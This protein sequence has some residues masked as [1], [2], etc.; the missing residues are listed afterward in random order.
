MMMSEESFE[1]ISERRA[2]WD[3]L[4]PE[5]RLDYFCCVSEL[6]LE[7]QKQGRSYRGTLYNVFGFGPESYILAFDAGYMDLHNMM[8]PDH[9]PSQNE[10]QLKERI[11]LLEGRLMHIA[12]AAAPY[13][14]IDRMARELIKHVEDVTPA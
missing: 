2:K 8:W 9:L 13:G 5:D 6:I 11:A 12:N 7:A 1:Y 4:T 14:Y 10:Q 3:A